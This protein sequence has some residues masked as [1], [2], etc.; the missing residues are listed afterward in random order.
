MQVAHNAR[1]H[2][3][4]NAARRICK[5]IFDEME[6][7]IIAMIRMRFDTV[8]K[9]ELSC[10]YA[11]KCSGAKGTLSLNIENTHAYTLSIDLL[12]LSE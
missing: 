7:H 3:L 6:N 8:E 5:H 10:I 1:N 4:M 2:Y 12:F 11:H 9:Q